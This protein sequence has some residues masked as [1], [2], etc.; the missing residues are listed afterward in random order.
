[1]GERKKRWDICNILKSKDFKKKEINHH[2]SNQTTRI[3]WSLMK[4]SSDCVPPLTSL[5]LLLL[6]TERQL[7]PD[8]PYYTALGII[9]QRGPE[10]ERQLSRPHS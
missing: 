10:R 5:S 6:W 8:C 9:L 1:M 3:L 7:Y 4:P 2:D